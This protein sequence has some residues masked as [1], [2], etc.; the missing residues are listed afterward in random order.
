M[1]SRR[2]L[3]VHSHNR[4][5]SKPCAPPLHRRSNHGG[6]RFTR[7]TRRD[8]GGSH[9]AHA[10]RGLP[11]SHRN[12]WVFLWMGGASAVPDFAAWPLLTLPRSAGAPV[13]PGAVVAKNIPNVV[14][15]FQP[16]LALL[17]LWCSVSCKKNKAT[18]TVSR[19]LGNY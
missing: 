18:S 16:S 4:Q 7:C 8:V 12:P 9:G 15:S 14:M 3:H 10:P 6:F 1:T 13:P 11:G 19:S 2:H 17:W 5:R